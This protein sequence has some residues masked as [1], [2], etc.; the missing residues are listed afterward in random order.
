MGPSDALFI[1]GRMHTSQKA[2]AVVLFIF[3]V[4]FAVPAIIHSA[5]ASATHGC[6]R[7]SDTL[8]TCAG[9]AAP[10]DPIGA[11]TPYR[12]PGNLTVW[13]CRK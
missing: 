3:V 5:T 7:L 6:S 10:P 2:L 4:A 12:T 9:D 8:L 11:C 1:L 13:T